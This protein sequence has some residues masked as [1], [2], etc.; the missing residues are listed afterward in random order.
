M[1]ALTAFALLCL[2]PVAAAAQT[3]G[4]EIDDLAAPTSA[5]FV[6]LDVAPA[7]VER[8]DNPKSFTLNLLNHLGASSGLPK[9]YAMEVAPYW[10]TFHPNLTFGAYQR[11]GPLQS[12]AQTFSVSIATA[13]LDEK[14]DADPGSRI[15]VGFRTQVWNGRPN[16][17]LE[18]RVAE[19]ETIN[20]TILDRLAQGLPI[21][22]Q[23]TEARTKALE[24]QGLDAERVGFFLAVAG[25]QVWS[26]PDGDTKKAQ[27]QRRG[28]WVT[29]SYRVRACNT[30]SQDCV[31]SLDFIGVLRTLKDPGK[32]VMWDYG[33]RLLWR[34]SRQLYLSMEALRRTGLESTEASGTSRTVGMLEYR[35]RTDLAVYGSFGRDFEKDSGARPL[36]SVMGLNVGFGSTPSV[37]PVTKPKE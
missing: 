22:E 9:D 16:A 36:V 10:L 24:I 31:A 27:V 2:Y 4:V 23:R 11:P 6:L 15:G 28:F 21:D 12:I 14:T 32:D 8:P 5:A 29:P 30:A 13:P 35:I 20:G 25:G 33:A 34:P 17:E 26:I 7:S 1:K 3:G 18:E 19:L 37:Q